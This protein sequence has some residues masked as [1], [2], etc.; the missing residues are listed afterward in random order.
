MLTDLYNQRKGKHKRYFPLGKLGKSK[1][2]YRASK[3]PYV[4]YTLLATVAPDGVG[5]A[6]SATRK[7]EKLE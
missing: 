1:L 7:Y 5:K 6:R 3:Q 2:N 4:C